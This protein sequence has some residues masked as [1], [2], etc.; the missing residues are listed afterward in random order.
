[1]RKDS[2][3]DQASCYVL[4][5][6]AGTFAFNGALFPYSQASCVLFWDIGNRENADTS[7]PAY[8]PA[9]Y[10]TYHIIDRANNLRCNNMAM[11]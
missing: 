6:H 4:I 2:T 3:N 1:M 8:L 10:A 11:D 5:S 9:I 7:A